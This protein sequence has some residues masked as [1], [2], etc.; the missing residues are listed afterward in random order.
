MA[1]LV[2]REWWECLR[3]DGASDKIKTKC[4]RRRRRR[5]RGESS[6]N[7][8]V[9]ACT[10]FANS[11]ASCRPTSTWTSNCNCSCSV[12]SWSC[13]EMHTG[14]QSGTAWT[15][16]GRT[17]RLPYSTCSSMCSSR[18]PSSSGYGALRTNCSYSTTKK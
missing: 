9:R 15:R 10:A 4:K 13:S 7:V 2:A 17:A 14:H 1:V 16:C 11:A 3:G 6:S 8:F 5:R 18:P 12:A